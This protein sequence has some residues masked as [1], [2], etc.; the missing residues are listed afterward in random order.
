MDFY[1]GYKGTFGKSDFGYD[2]GVLQY[3]YPGTH[4]GLVTAAGSVK[5]DTLEIYGALS[6]KWM[7]AKY[8]QSMSKKTFGVNDSRGTSYFDLSINYPITDKMTLLA[9]YGI[10]KF[11]GA[12]GANNTNASYKDWKLGASYALPKDFTIGG[13]FTGTKMT[14]EQKTFYTNAADNRMV[15]KDTFTVFVAKT[16]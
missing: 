13:Y 6:W 16:F 3:Y 10:Q 1:G 8:S 11:D 5:A 12:N 14:D 2:V 4:D 9:H 15:G 7:S